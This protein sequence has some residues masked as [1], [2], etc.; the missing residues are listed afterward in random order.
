MVTNIYQT[1]L[2]PDQVKYVEIQAKDPMVLLLNSYR[3]TK[4]QNS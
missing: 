2:E 4:S 3:T 1:M